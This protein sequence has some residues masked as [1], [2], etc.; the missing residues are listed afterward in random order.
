[1]W[2]FRTQFYCLKGWSYLLQKFNENDY[3][4]FENSDWGNQVYLTLFMESC[5]NSSRVLVP[6]ATSTKFRPEKL[7]NIKG[8][9]IES[10]ISII[11]HFIF[12][13]FSVRILSLEQMPSK[14][15]VEIPTRIQLCIIY[16]YW[17]IVNHK[18]LCNFMYTKNQYLLAWIRSELSQLV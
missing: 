4:I 16:C 15:L 12:G 17:L 7:A 5:W 1:M 13:I 14:M 10:S 11:L 3:G 9:A 2:P 8:S 18:V 6:S